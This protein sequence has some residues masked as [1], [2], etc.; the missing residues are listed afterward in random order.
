MIYS[1]IYQNVFYSKDLQE[2]L[3]VTINVT[4]YILRLNKE[5]LDVKMTYSIRYNQRYG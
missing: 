5:T 3:Q 1:Y 2:E 4:Q